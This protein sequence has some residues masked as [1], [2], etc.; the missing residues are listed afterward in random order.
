MSI[1][2]IRALLQEWKAASQAASQK[3]AGRASIIQTAMQ[4]LSSELSAETEA[5]DNQLTSGRTSLMGSRSSFIASTS[6]D[7]S[8]EAAGHEAANAAESAGTAGAPAAARVS[9]T[10]SK[11]LDDMA[12]LQQLMQ[13]EAA[14]HQEQFGDT[15]EVCITVLSCPAGLRCSSMSS[16]GYTVVLSV[17]VVPETS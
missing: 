9:V 16:V 13:A 14:K 3:L 12:A 15:L 5:S 2:C 6:G 17:P 4:H 8:A 11:V 10:T 7:G 1:A